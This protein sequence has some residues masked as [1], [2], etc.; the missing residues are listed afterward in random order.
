MEVVGLRIAL[1]HYSAPPVV[2]GVESVLANQARVFAANGHQVCVI[3][4]RGEPLGVH[5]PLWSE[6]L[7]DTR[8]PEV[9]RVKKDLDAGRVGQDFHELRKKIEASLIRLLA[10]MDLLIAHNVCS[11]NKNLPLTAAL[12]RVFAVG[13]DTH[14]VAWH[15]DLAWSSERYAHELHA[16]YPWDLLRSAWEGTTQ[17]V[18]SQSRREEWRLLCGLA[19]ELIRVI[20][21]GLDVG[22]FGK[23]ETLTL[24]ILKRLRVLDA[25]PLVLLP[26][27]IIGRKN[28]ELAL[29]VIAQLRATVFPNAQL[30]V[31]GPLGPHDP[32]N[33]VYFRRLLALRAELGISEAVHFLAEHVSSWIP[34][35]VISDF[36]RLADV[37]LLPSFEEGFGLPILEAGAAHL[38]I[39]CSDIPPFRALA[40]DFA[41][42]FDPHAAPEVVAGMVQSCLDANRAIR[43]SRKVRADFSWEGIYRSMILPLLDVARRNQ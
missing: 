34:D 26:V 2:G 36:Y 32:T 11:L 30:V 15:H 41:D 20:P 1:L 23:F 5:I 35:N 43:W 18:V 33:Q 22:T 14:L 12:N 17:V 27:R 16:G 3:A 7:F 31:T 38:P 10:D 25:D 19:P 21:N 39:V 9:L 24:D 4:G 28:I 13:R 6:S 29:H 37:V 42:Y 8:H 40:G